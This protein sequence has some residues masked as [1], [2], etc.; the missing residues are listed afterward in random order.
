VSDDEHEGHQLFPSQAAFASNQPKEGS[1]DTEFRQRPD[2]RFF[3]KFYSRRLRFPDGAEFEMWSFED[4]RSGRTFPAPL[5]RVTEGDIVHTELKP[6]KRVH[7]IHHH[8]LEPDPRNDGVGHTSFE[9]S[10]S[11]TYQWR[12]DVGFPGDVNNGSAGSYFYHCHVNTALHVQMG[13]VGA[14]IVDP[15]VHPDYPVPAGAR[16][17]FVDG[18]LYDVASE[19]L[20]LPYAVDPRWHDMDH[21][22][23]LSGED[24]GL[25]RFEPSHYYVLGGN[26]SQPATR[27]D[28]QTLREMRVNAEGS[29]H[30]ALVRVLNLDYFPT[31]VVFTDSAGTRVPMAEIIAHDGRA[32]RDTSDPDGPSPPLRDTGHPLL[33]DALAFGSAERYDVLLRPPRPGT[34]VAHVEFFDWSE[35]DVRATRTVPIIAR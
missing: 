21:A 28:V 26:L 18:P 25:N 14:L 32:F 24:V 33:S 16:R 5:I 11:Y 15:R 12:P 17:S 19:Y 6:S 31:R 13:M 23:G 2:K 1:P 27:D 3:R 4:E 30:P 20:L 34:Y 22:A 35:R 8:G 7:T 29:G 10:G 9:V